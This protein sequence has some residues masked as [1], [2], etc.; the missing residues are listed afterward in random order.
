MSDRVLTSRSTDTLLMLS[1]VVVG[2][3]VAHVLLDMVRRFI[4]MRIAVEA[5]SKLGAPVLGAAAKASQGGSSR[6]FQ[7][8]GDLQH[9]RSFLTGP[10]LLTMLDA[11]VAPLYLLAVF[12]IHPDLGW[13]VAGH[14]LRSPR[15]SPISTRRSPPSRSRRANAFGTRANLQADAMARNAQVINAMGMIPEAVAMWGRETAESLKAQVLAQDRNIVDG[16]RLQIRAPVHADRDPRLGR[17]AFARRRA[18]R[19]HDD[20]RLDRRQPR[21]CPDRGH[22]RG[23]A[24]LHPRPRRLRAH[25]GAVAELDR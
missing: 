2:A 6:E 19:R 8:L 25:Q 12:L 14:G 3:I 23:M 21:A 11:P 18:D 22:D 16:R 7:T 4:L 15:R 9:M 5:E 17:M 1:L 13:I 20:R 24:K 10:V